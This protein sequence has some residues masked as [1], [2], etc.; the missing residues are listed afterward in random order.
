M[1]IKPRAPQKPTLNGIKN[2]QY[3]ERFFLVS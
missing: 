2:E 1:S 3:A